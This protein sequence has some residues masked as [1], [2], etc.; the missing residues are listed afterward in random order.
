MILKTQI[1]LRITSDLNISQSYERVVDES[2]ARETGEQD[3]RAFF[4]YMAGF[5]ATLPEADS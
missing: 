2:E 5:T 3:A 1:N 4:E